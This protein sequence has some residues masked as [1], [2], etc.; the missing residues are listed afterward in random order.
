MQPEAFDDVASAT[1]PLRETRVQPFWQ[2]SNEQAVGQS[3]F[4]NQPS[5]H[6]HDGVSWFDRSVERRDGY[7]WVNL[8]RDLDDATAALCDECR[9]TCHGEEDEQLVQTLVSDHV[10]DVTNVLPT[11]APEWPHERGATAPAAPH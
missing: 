10:P 7:V 11:G 6:A 3:D 4:G 5:I 1:D 2:R 8:A 9:P